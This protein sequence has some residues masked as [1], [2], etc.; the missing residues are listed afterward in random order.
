MRSYYLSCAGIVLLIVCS[1]SPLL[2]HAIELESH[3]DPVVIVQPQSSPNPNSLRGLTTPDVA[4]NQPTLRGINTPDVAPTRDPAGPTLTP[5]EMLDPANTVSASA[6]SLEEDLDCEDPKLDVS[7]M[8]ESSRNF[9]LSTTDPQA[10]FPGHPCKEFAPGLMSI[11]KSATR[12]A[13][14]M[15]SNLPWAIRSEN[16]AKII[17]RIP[18]AFASFQN[19]ALGLVYGNSENNDVRPG[20]SVQYSVGCNAG[21]T[22]A[23]AHDL[24]RLEN[25]KT[26]ALVN[27]KGD[28]LCVLE[29]NWGEY[30]LA[31]VNNAKPE[32][33]VSVDG[34]SP[35][36]VQAPASPPTLP[37]SQIPLMKLCVRSAPH[38]SSIISAAIDLKWPNRSK[39]EGCFFANCVSLAFP[40]F[41]TSFYADPG[42]SVFLSNPKNIE[43][44]LKT[45]NRRLSSGT[46]AWSE[47]SNTNFTDPNMPIVDNAKVDKDV[48]E[49]EDKYG[50][51]G[52]E[53]IELATCMSAASKESIYTALGA[54]PI[55]NLNTF[56]TEFLFRILF[57]FTGAIT[58]GCAIYS[59]IMIQLSQG[60]EGLTKA[61]ETLTHCLSGL[62]LIIFAVFLL[63]FIGWDILRLPGLG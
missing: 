35:R 14:S 10:G 42:S 31:K 41:E 25:P 51:K 24:S 5:L 53:V 36:L 26:G 22:C 6:K 60:G 15:H 19:A 43:S 32:E 49:F 9:C 33:M 54:V 13:K 62:A 28:N 23:Q 55:N 30:L 63:R 39:V 3:T 37:P 44:I 46:R 34:G 21:A 7:K 2:V 40:Q 16:G 17:E 50:V 38:G 61:R 8:S 58:L 4:P 11:V 45:I 27:T 59:A 56:V 18:S 52:S 47:A 48:A 1:L 20:Y 57:G 12:T 29:E